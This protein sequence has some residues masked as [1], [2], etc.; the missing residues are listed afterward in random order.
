MSQYNAASRVGIKCGLSHPSVRF[1][2]PDTTCNTE[3]ASVDEGSPAITK[4]KE[5]ELNDLFNVDSSAINMGAKPSIHFT[6]SARISVRSPAHTL[7][8]LHDNGIKYFQ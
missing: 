3:E 4:K 6:R 2:Q 8:W 5:I 1:S 7:R